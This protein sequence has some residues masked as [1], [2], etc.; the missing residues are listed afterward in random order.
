MKLHMFIVR[1]QSIQ[2]GMQAPVVLDI[3]KASL[4]KR[5]S[6]FLFDGIL[7]SVVAVLFAFVLAHLVGYDGYR[8]ALNEKYDQYAA[9][10]AVKLNPTTEEYEAMTEAER[11]RFQAAY[12]AM[13]RDGDAIYAYRMTLQ[14]TVLIISFCLLIAYLLMEF[15]IPLFLKNGQTL[16]KKIFGLGL[17]RPDGVKIST[18]SLF[19]RAILGKYTLETMIP[20]LILLML[21]LGT[22][23]LTGWIV[24]G[25]IALISVIVMAV[26]Q[27]HSL[28]HDLMAGTVVID[29]PS[30]MIFDTPEAMMA[31]KEQLE[32][33][34]A[35]HDPY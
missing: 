3:Q 28:I 15:L 2:K 1:F 12:D 34:S 32:A 11:A 29:L 30:Q 4:W 20:V 33:Q 27:N 21:Y 26:T 18:L 24:L 14:L 8:T 5:I 19:V 16:G 13:S 17:M 10:Y 23:G 25:L 22:L 31:Y 35:V 9:E 6:A 7:F